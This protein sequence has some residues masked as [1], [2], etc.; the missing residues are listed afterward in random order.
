MNL[1]S[2]A[3]YFK[4]TIQ[5]SELYHSPKPVNDVDLL[6]PEFKDKVDELISIYKED[7]EHEPFILE[8]YRSNDLQLSYFNR[9]ASK[10]R[11]D[12]MHH[13]G[14][15]VDLVALNDNGHVSYDILDYDSLRKTAK[16]LGLT[17]LTWEL[18]HFQFVP[19]EKQNEL[20][21]ICYS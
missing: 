3:N 6:Y 1:Q 7:H 2:I 21:Q 17:I 20:R 10:I 15:A 11:K 9:G 16:E 18:C 19:V 13:F 14:I 12:G 8:T 5:S 4:N